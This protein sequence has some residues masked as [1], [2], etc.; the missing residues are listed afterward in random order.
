VERDDLAGLNL[1]RVP[2]V[3]IECGNMRNVRDARL[4][5]SP[6]FQRAAAEAIALAMARFLATRPGR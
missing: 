6:R 5:R 3:L 1:T 2:Q 4:L